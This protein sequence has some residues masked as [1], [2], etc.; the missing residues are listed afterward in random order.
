LCG[1]RTLNSFVTVP[2][3]VKTVSKVTVSAE[4]DNR[5]DESVSISS[6]LQDMKTKETIEKK[7]KIPG[8]NSIKNNLKQK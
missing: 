7:S 5:A 3:V 8:L 4:K 6:S 1:L 2:I